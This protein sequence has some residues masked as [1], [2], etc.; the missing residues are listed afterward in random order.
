ML[1]SEALLVNQ[2]P[3]D[4]HA[5][6]LKCR[7]WSCELCQHY[8]RKRVRRAAREGNPNMFLTLTVDPA[9]HAGP[10]EAARDLVR[11]W[12]LL[13][14]RIARKTG[15]PAPPFLAVFEATKAGNPHLHILLR[16]G[17]LPK[18][19]ISDAMRELTGAYIVDVSFV[20][21]KNRVAAYVSKYISKTP[22]GFEGSKRWWRSHDFEVEPEEYEP[23][24]R[25]GPY[26]SE[27][28]MSIEAY[29]R[30]LLAQGFVMVEERHD[31]LR[32]QWWTKAGAPSPW[33]TGSGP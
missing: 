16:S 13:R 10:D 7:R 17:F 12:V 33:A 18:Q 15:K 19:W 29:T 25:F 6:I 11:A 27:V 31:Y 4:G 28:R 23:F 32:W 14:R 9:R 1:C 22:T 3:T 5:T 2:D 20:P 30:K 8:N 21:D 26:V 24:R